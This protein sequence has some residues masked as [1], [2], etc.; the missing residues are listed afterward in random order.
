MQKNF[1]YKIVT[2]LIQICNRNVTDLLREC[3]NFVR[4]SQQLGNGTVLLEVRYRYQFVTRFCKV[5][6]LLRLSYKFVSNSEIFVAFGGKD[7]WSINCTPKFNVNLNICIVCTIFSLVVAQ[8]AHVMAFQ[9]TPRPK[10]CT[11]RLFLLLRF[12]A[13]CWLHYTLIHKTWLNDL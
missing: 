9:P 5:T 7:L 2:Q 8:R 6:N 3:I 13:W 10:L 1:P 4:I 12:D 11:K